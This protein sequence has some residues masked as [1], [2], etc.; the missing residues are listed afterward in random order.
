MLRTV[1][2]IVPSNT[3]S[4]TYYTI[5]CLLIAKV[6]GK[7]VLTDCMLQGSVVI[8]DFPDVPLAFCRKIP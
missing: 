6:E 5:L 8:V 7:A 1:I 4:M 2:S 3:A